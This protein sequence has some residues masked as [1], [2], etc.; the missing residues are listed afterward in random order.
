MTTQQRRQLLQQVTELT[1][2]GEYLKAQTLYEM[3]MQDYRNC[4]AR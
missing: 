2:R 3:V 4:Q 1:N